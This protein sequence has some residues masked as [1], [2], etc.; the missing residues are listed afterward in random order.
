MVS[1][2]FP[3]IPPIRVAFEEIVIQQVADFEQQVGVNPRAVEDFV[4]VL[5]RIAQL[6]GEPCDAAPLPLQFLLD[7]VADVWFFVHAALPFV[8]PRSS[9]SKQN[10]R[11]RYCLP[12]LQASANALAVNK[13]NSPRPNDVSLSPTYPSLPNFADFTRQRKEVSKALLFFVIF[14][15]LQSY[16]LWHLKY[17]SQPDCNACILNLISKSLQLVAPYDSGSMVVLP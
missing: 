10:G 1:I 9:A 5:P 7:E 14:T 15:Q 3:F 6:L 11:N 4:G 12:V 13:Q 2:L 8:E 16:C 17:S